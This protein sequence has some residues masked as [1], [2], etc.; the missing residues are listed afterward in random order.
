M[1]GKVDLTT[2]RWMIVAL[3]EKGICGKV[4]RRVTGKYSMHQVGIQR[5]V[6]SEKN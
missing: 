4:Y 2:I 1:Y 3:D 5:Y 6:N